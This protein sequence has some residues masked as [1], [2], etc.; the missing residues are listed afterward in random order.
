[1]FWQCCCHSFP[2]M[3]SL[4]CSS[5]WS[6]PLCQ[7]SILKA[8]SA[9]FDLSASS[10][11]TPA[12]SLIFP[13]FLAL[14]SRLLPLSFSSRSHLKNPIWAPARCLRCLNAALQSW[15]CLLSH[16]SCGA[17]SPVFIQSAVRLDRVS[18]PGRTCRDKPL[19]VPFVSRELG[20]AAL[21]SCSFTSS[22]ACYLLQSSRRLIAWITCNLSAPF[23]HA[24]TA[25][26]ITYA[27]CNS[28]TDCS[29]LF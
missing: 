26:F 6:L 9:N 28:Q 13:S 14:Y 7:I 12:L 5:H 25:L 16:S 24:N 19:P 23:S 29:F 17:A 8:L 21:T 27:G 20:K 3:F 10:A 1:M 11:C 22:P 15:N 2:L 18:K 4:F